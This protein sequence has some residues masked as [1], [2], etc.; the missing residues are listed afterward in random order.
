LN[1]PPLQE[2]ECKSLKIIAYALSLFEEG[3]PAGGGSSRTHKQKISELLR[4]QPL[5]L[6]NPP[7]LQEEECKSLKII[8]YALSLL[9]RESP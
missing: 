3:V 8:A 9:K 1:P 5:T 6:L 2:E 7:P 4:L